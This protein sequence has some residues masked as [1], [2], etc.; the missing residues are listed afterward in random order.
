MELVQ[1]LEID[2]VVQHQ[3]QILL[4]HVQDL[5]L[6]HH[7]VLELDLLLE[8]DVVHVLNLEEQP[9]EHVGQLH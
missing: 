2:V 8:I 9:T 6:D 5:L 3:A 4:T 7:L 1:I